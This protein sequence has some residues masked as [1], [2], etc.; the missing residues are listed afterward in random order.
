MNAINY[1]FESTDD[2]KYDKQGLPVGTHTVMIIGEEP[3]VKDGI[4]QGIIVEY[5]VVKGEYKGKKAKTWYLTT[6]ASATTANIAKQNIKRIA[7]ATGKAVSGAT[8]LKGRVFVVEVAEQKNDS[9]RT[10]IKRYFP[11]G[12][13]VERAPF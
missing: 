3:F 5:E 7:D 10:E 1:G 6:H 8:P 9:D 4:T 2:V 13:N 12:H 11:E